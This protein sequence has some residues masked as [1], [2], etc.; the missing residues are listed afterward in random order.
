MKIKFICTMVIIGLL[1]CPLQVAAQS[2]GTPVALLSELEQ[3]LYGQVQSDALITR[4]ERIETEIFG[5]PQSGPVMTRIDRIDEFLAG[6]KEGSG[7]KLQLNLIEWIFLAKL[8]SG[9]PLMKRL[10]RIETEFYGRIQSGSLVE[11]IRNLMLNV[12]GSSNLDTAPVDVPA[13]TLVEIQLLTDVDSAKSKVG[14]SVEYQVASNV[15]IDGRIVIPKGTRGVGKVTEVT[16]AGSLGKNG[17]VVIDFGSISA[18]DGT[19]IRLRIS[20]KA[21]EENR[22]LELA[23]GASMAGVIL[24]GPVG[25]VGGYFVKGEDVQIQAGAKF[26][27]ETEK[28]T[29]TLGVRLVPVK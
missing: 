11:R 25:L 22:R 16:K 20:E 29:Q 5:K 3:V 26:F 1:I 10:E 14:D 19:T 18:F 7:L 6:S 8:T 12:W 13:E 28:T 9:E 17:R 15:E 21:T 23:A 2:A 24:L 4:V 27:V